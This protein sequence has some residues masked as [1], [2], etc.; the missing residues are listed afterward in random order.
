MPSDDVDGVLA[1]RGRHVGEPVAGESVAPEG[2]LCVVKVEHL[3]CITS[4]KVARIPHIFLPI[5]YL[6]V[7]LKQDAWPALQS[8][9]RKV[10]V[11]GVAPE[12]RLSLLGLVNLRL[13]LDPALNEDHPQF[14]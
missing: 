8:P 1:G 4:K 12:G 13:T 10:D 2:V 14:C 3:L 9:G 6:V 7:D 11:D 5:S